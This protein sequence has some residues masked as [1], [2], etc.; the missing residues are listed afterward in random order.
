MNNNSFPG[1]SDGKKSACNAGDLGS[2]LVGKIPWRRAWQPTLVFLPGESP[3]TK[4]PGRLQSMGWQRVCAWLSAHTHTHTHTNNKGLSDHS[5]N[6]KGFRSY[7]PRMETNQKYFLLYH[8]S[9]RSQWHS[10]VVSTAV[11]LSS[12][13]MVSGAGQLF[14][15][16][17]QASWGVLHP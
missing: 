9:I 14:A 13:T 12:S 3:W 11:F 4:E 7:V 17:S 2:I 8:S 15:E 5:G 16:L 6:S 10:R 1:G